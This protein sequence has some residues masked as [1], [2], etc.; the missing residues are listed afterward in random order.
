M[1][2][3]QQPQQPSMDEM[4]KQIQEIQRVIQEMQAQFVKQEFKSET[5]G[6]L[7]TVKALGSKEVLSVELRPEAIDEDDPEMLDD[8]VLTAVN[9][10]FKDIDDTFELEMSKITRGFG[11]A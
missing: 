6:G 11:I 5:G 3:P 10:L 7:I 8:L 2:S 1:S 9:K 4:M